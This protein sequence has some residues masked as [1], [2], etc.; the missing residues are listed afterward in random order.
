MLGKE[1]NSFNQGRGKNERFALTMI[2]IL[3]DFGN[4]LAESDS[5]IHGGGSLLNIGIDHINQLHNGDG[6]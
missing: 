1:F 4:D 2:E 3:G 5:D 6:H